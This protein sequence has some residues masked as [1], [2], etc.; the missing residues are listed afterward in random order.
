MTNPGQTCVTE[1]RSV[2]TIQ[3]E[4]RVQRLVI[5]PG[6]VRTPELHERHSVRQVGIV[7]ENTLAVLVYHRQVSRLLF[8]DSQSGHFLCAGSTK[9]PVGARTSS[10]RPSTR[11]CGVPLP[12]SRCGT[13]STRRSSPRLTPTSSTSPGL[14]ARCSRSATWVAE[15]SPSGRSARPIGTTETPAGPSPAGAAASVS[16][17]CYGYRYRFPNTLPVQTTPP[18]AS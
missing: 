11:P 12:P 2:F 16:G 6:G 17:Y 13:C 9:R 14:T 7:D 10:P 4:R 3:S 1:G 8:V 5:D 15:P 18:K